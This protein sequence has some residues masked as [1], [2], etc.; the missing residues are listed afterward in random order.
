[1]FSPKYL[2]CIKFY[3]PN[4][5]DIKFYF[6]DDQNLIY[7]IR[8]NFRRTSFWRLQ[9][10]RQAIIAPTKINTSELIQRREDA[11]Q[12]LACVSQSCRVSQLN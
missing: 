3:K 1:M 11:L 2:D 9:K 10:D 12:K 6:M 8:T 5:F 4:E 7:L